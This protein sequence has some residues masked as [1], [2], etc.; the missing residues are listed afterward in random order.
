MLELLG[1]FLFSTIKR[2]LIPFGLHHVFYLPFWQTSLG[3]TEVINGITYV[4]AQN[5]YFAQLADP[6]I[7]HISA[8]V[9]QYFGG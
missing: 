9:T 3:G 2:L 1:A 5:I 6:S 4:G 7:T 8:S